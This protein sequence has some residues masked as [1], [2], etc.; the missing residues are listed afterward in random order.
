METIAKD[1]ETD[2]TPEVPFE[3]E[4]LRRWVEVHRRR[5]GTADGRPGP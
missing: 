5:A 1:A 4:A 2:V 3:A